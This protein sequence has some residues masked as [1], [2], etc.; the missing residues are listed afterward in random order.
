MKLLLIA[1]E[2]R[3]FAG[4]PE[5]V[6]YSC[7]G[8]GWCRSAR[9]GE[10]EALL[11]ANGA[12]IKHAA[13]AT[14][15]AGRAFRPEA[16]VSTG[17]CGALASTLKISDIVVATLV[18]SD[19]SVNFTCTPSAELPFHAGPVATTNHVVR[20][21]AEKGRL[22]NSGAI[23]VEMEAAG[24]AQVAKAFC[25]PFFCIRAVT[26][27]ADED[28]ANDF[29]TAL[30]NDGHFDTIKILTGALRHPGVRVPEL[31]RLKNRA[32]QAAR[33]LGV[34]LVDCRF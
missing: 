22:R 31:L 33:S 19:N 34:F 21:S 26:D 15:I 3:E 32:Q 4:I 6:E 12:G 25:V 17:F 9:I 29:N 7:S 24:P 10:H 1:A 20:T 28:M 18:H 2:P 8:V 30:R 14:E 27:L 23:A 11:V 5:A 13:A 16:V